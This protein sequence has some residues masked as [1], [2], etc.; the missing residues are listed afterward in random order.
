MADR[1]EFTE[2]KEPASD[3]QPT[4]EQPSE[5]PQWM[6]E[7]L[8]IISPTSEL[9]DW[10]VKNLEGTDDSQELPQWMKNHLD[11]SDHR[12]ELPDSAAKKREGA[13]EQNARVLYRERIIGGI[14]RESFRREVPQ[15]VETP[16]QQ[17]DLEKAAEVWHVQE[18]PYSCATA[19]Q[20]YIID[21]FLNVDMQE[22]D[23]TKLAQDQ[24][25]LKEHG[26]GLADI[27]NLLE[28]YGIETQRMMD[29]GFPEIKS[30]LDDG[31]R[32]IVAVNSFV[33]NREWAGL[34]PVVSPNHAIEILGVEKKAPDRIDYI[35]NDPG[36]LDGC[37]KRVP[38]E[39]ME[40]ARRGSDGFMVVAERP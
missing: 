23:L 39:L 12:S 24:N 8:E 18:G 40:L 21:E 10:V 28:Y 27:G 25:W 1:F 38:Q 22:R 37:R 6:K 31:N 2:G 32:V 17:Y 33:L 14:L 5:L 35:I 11:A 15:P 9:P 30:A 4:A 16:E 13:P 26:T 34:V 20:E 36:T 7:N 19:V 3:L 29:A